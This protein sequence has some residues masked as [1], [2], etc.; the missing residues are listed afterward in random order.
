MSARYFSSGVGGGLGLVYTDIQE[1]ISRELGL[2]W[3]CFDSQV[4]QSGK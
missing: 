3:L 4:P 2:Y 1:N